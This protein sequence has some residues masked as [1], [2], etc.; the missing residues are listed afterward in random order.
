MSYPCM[1]LVRSVEATDTVPEAEQYVH[2]TGCYSYPPKH[3]AATRQHHLKQLPLCN[4]FHHLRRHLLHLFSPPFSHPIHHHISFPCRSPMTSTAVEV[5]RRWCPIQRRGKGLR[6]RPPPRL[7]SVFL[8]IST[9]APVQYIATLRRFD[10][11][12]ECR[13]RMK[14]LV[15]FRRLQR[16]S[17]LIAVNSCWRRTRSMMVVDSTQVKVAQA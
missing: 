5:H 8:R 7:P 6:A 13:G 9:S 16:V 11:E 15:P 4:R 17:E 1:S 10:R 2:A 14:R 3:S 12:G